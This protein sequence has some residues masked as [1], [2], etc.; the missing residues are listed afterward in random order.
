M[1]RIATQIGSTVSKEDFKYKDVQNS[2][3]ARERFL[4]AL[5]NTNPLVHLFAFYSHGACMGVEGRR[6]KEAAV[7]YGRKPEQR[8]SPRGEGFV[9]FDSF[10][11]YLA[12]CIGAPAV[13]NGYAVD[14]YWDRRTELDQM[15]A[16][17][18]EHIASQS[19][20]RRYKGVADLVSCC[21]SVRLKRE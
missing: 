21:S 4:K 7:A 1:A 19:I 3:A 14:I 15:K 16:S 5:N 11:S 8:S 20:T 12:S 18:D 9:P 17:F 2:E 13:T 10:I 6:T